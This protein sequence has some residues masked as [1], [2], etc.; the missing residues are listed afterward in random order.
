[1]YKYPKAKIYPMEGNI[2]HVYASYACIK[3]DSLYNTEIS[4]MN[5]KTYFKLKSLWTAY[6][7]HLSNLKHR[8]QYCYA[9]NVLGDP[10]VTANIYCKQNLPNTDRQKYSTDLR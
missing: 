10:E 7:L 9:C 6:N 2:M 1:M 8:F 4:M 3:F 5:T